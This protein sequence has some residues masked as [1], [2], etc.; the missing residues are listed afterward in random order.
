MS[1]DVLVDIPLAF[2][3][4]WKRKEVRKFEA[5]DVY[6]ISLEDLISLKKYSN[7]IQDRQDI[8][9]LSKIKNGKK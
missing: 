9:L 8:L 3:E 7:R 5:S 6:F 2:D 1:V 4:M